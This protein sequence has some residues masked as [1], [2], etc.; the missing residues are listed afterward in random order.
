[1]N[2]RF[3]V[4]LIVMFSAQVLSAQNYFFARYSVQEGLPDS[5]INDIC[6]DQKGVLWMATAS[7]L[8]AFNGHEFRN[9]SSVDGLAAGGVKSLFFDKNNGLWLG[10]YNGGLSYFNGEAFSE[11]HLE[12]EELHKDILSIAGDDK[13]NIWLATFGEGAIRI[14]HTH[15]DT[16]KKQDYAF[17]KGQQGLSDIVLDV[18]QFKGSIYFVTDYGIRSFNPDSMSFRPQYLNGLPNY[19]RLLKMTAGENGLWLGSQQGDI[20]FYDPIN[21]KTKAVFSGTEYRNPV[22]C[23][24]PVLGGTEIWAGLWDKGLFKIGSQGIIEEFNILNGLQSNQISCLLRDD[25][26]N[27]FIGT[28]ES[29]LL[30]FSGSKFLHFTEESGLKDRQIWSICSDQNSIWLGTNRGLINMQGLQSG[31]ALDLT[32]YENSES[33]SNALKVRFIQVDQKDRLW[34]GTDNKRLLQYHPDLDM[35]LPVRDLRNWFQGNLNSVTGLQTAVDGSLWIGT[36][37]GLLN[38][39]PDTKQVHRFSQRDGLTGNTITAL[40]TDARQQLW[41]AALGN[42]IAI[43]TKD[44]AFKKANIPGKFTARCFAENGDDLW[45]GTE[46]RGIII[47]HNSDSTSVLNSSNGLLSDR[48]SMLYKTKGGLMLIGTN[49]GLNIYNPDT[50][51]LFSYGS[52]HGFTGIEVKNDAVLEYA[53]GKILIGTVE[54]LM[55]L[56]EDQLKLEE[57]QPDVYIEKMLVNLNKHT[58]NEKSVFPYTQNSFYF[59]FISPNYIDPAAVRYKVRL[60]GLEEEWRP[61]APQNFISFSGLSPGDYQ[62]EILAASDQGIWSEHPATYSFRIRPPFYQ[63]WWFVA[64]VILFI[65]T[66][67]YTYILLREKKLRREKKILEDKVAVRTREVT[68]KNNQLAQKNKDITDSINYARRI[69]AA[70]MRPVSDLNKIMPE[71]FIFYQ[72]RDIVSGDFY[73]FSDKHELAVIAAS[74]CTGHGVPGAFMSMIGISY[75]NEIVNEKA[76]LEPATILNL[77]RDNLIS[78]LQQKGREGDTK[79]GMDMALVAIDL[80]NAT[81]SYAGAYNSLYLYRDELK[82]NEVPE[83][84]SQIGNMFEIKG[85]RMPVGVSTKDHKAFTNHVIQLK[86]GDRF[87]L[88]TDGYIDQF[89]G[90][91]GKKFLNKRFRE[92]MIELIGKPCSDMPTELENA[93]VQWRGDN[94]QIDDVLV[95]GG[96]Y[97]L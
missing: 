63:R 13:G 73:W 1:M 20:I 74:D 12:G 43:K 77:L 93:F 15:S 24:L 49:R 56:Q 42:G 50:K 26:G 51:A 72:P 83:G 75:L 27:L 76:I 28:H 7:G 95:I 33:N 68:E 79:E 11:I 90:D 39:N 65:I 21:K 22:S 4:L 10:H 57:K 18:A 97:H 55:L 41:I 32:E 92:L 60:L 91:H 69:Q 45:I 96:T 35:F 53:K 8:S 81:L 62:L 59:Q 86:D 66:I 25:E 19:V 67:I 46:G 85:D 23:I 29:G 78:V 82:D 80:K 9:Y 88:T 36:L 34:V 37:N 84:A 61:A 87:F 54:G 70:I 17:Y 31:A 89:G 38:F 30:M 40:Y 71:S 47:C 44:G 48:I 58:L 16:I 52:K 5:K 3:L 94:E 2:F 14:D 6:M 64:L